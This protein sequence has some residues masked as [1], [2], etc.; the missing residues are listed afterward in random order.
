MFIFHAFDPHQH[1]AP[2]RDT[3]NKGFFSLHP[4]RSIGYLNWYRFRKSEFKINPV[5]LTFPN[6]HGLVEDMMYVSQGEMLISRR[7]S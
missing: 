6:M 1:A 4:F 5:V 7:D 3:K 2:T